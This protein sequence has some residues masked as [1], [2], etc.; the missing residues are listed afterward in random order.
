MTVAD[1][2]RGMDDYELASYL[3][4]IERKIIN[5]KPTMTREELYFDWLELLQGELAEE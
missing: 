1:W 2:I 5:K 3:T 4:D